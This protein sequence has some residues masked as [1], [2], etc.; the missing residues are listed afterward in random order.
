MA[1][2]RRLQLSF[3]ASVALHAFV[4]AS[5]WRTIVAP[6]RARLTAIPIALV[7]GSGGGGGAPPSPAPPAAVPAPPPVTE[8]SPVA[9]APHPPAPVQATRP[10]RVVPSRAPAARPDVAVARTRPG[11]GTGSDGGTG[12]GSGGGDGAGHGAGEGAGNGDGSG[13]VRVADGNPVP[14]Y[15]LIARRLHV[16]GEVLLDIVVGADGRPADVRVLRSSGN[17]A[18]DDSA[19]GTVRSSWRFIPAHRDGQAVESR[20]TYL[21]RF[22]LTEGRG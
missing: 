20:G 5:V 10:R 8:P 18:L 7:G 1:A 2:R 15:P 9:E 6:P 4:L 21:I 11:A 22:R 16:E 14:P 17:S 13:N 19:L 3:L 12:G